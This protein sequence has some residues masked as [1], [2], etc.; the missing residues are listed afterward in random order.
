M[1]VSPHTRR[2]AIK[3]V[4][5][6]TSEADTLPIW[7]MRLRKGISGYG[8]GSAE[9]RYVARFCNRYDTP[10]AEIMIDIRGAV[11]SGA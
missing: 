11:R 8:L 1:C 10:M 4:R 6:V 9:K 7:N 3:G 2:I 5:K